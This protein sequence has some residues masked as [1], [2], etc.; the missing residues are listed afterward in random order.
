MGAGREKVSSHFFFLFALSQFSGPDHLRAWKRLNWVKCL[1]LVLCEGNLLQTDIILLGNLSGG[2]SKYW[3]F[4]QGTLDLQPILPSSFPQTW[5]SDTFLINPYTFPSTAT[6]SP[7]LNYSTVVSL[8]SRP[9]VGSQGIKIIKILTI[10]VMIVVQWW[11]WWWWW[12][13]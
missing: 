8:P 5:V 13:Q 3:L 11:W 10:M 6:A 2:I 1:W 4:S 9:S 7:P 12:W